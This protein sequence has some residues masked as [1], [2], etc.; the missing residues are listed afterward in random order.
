MRGRFFKQKGTPSFDFLC[1]FCYNTNYNR[2]S[3]TSTQATASNQYVELY[4][5][6]PWWGAWKNFHWTP[7][8]E[9]IGISESVINK[10]KKLKK[11]ILIHIY[12]Y[13]SYTITPTKAEKLAK[14]FNSYYTARSGVKLLVIPRSDCTKYNK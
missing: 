6:Q 14:E 13:G 1:Y 2:G 3:M 10:A 5:H 7:N 11:K 9:G 12:R 4:L 8:V